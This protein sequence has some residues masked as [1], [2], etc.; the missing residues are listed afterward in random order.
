METSWQDYYE[1]DE[2]ETVSESHYYFVKIDMKEI[3]DIAG[4][5]FE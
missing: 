4:G 3:K 5:L 2:Y 1:E